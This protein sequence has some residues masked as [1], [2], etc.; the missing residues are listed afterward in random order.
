MRLRPWI[1]DTQTAPRRGLKRSSRQPTIQKSC[2]FTLKIRA[3]R[4][5]L[6]LRIAF[7]DLDRK[8]FD[9]AVYPTSKVFNGSGSSSN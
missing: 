9:S 6:E 1:D 7:R 5:H 3:E 2:F 8:R 4:C